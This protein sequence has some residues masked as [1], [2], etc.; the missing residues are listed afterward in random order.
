MNNTERIF[1]H[2]Q[3]SG[4]IADNKKAFKQLTLLW[5]NILSMKPDDALQHI[6]NTITVR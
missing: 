3:W 5:C 2:G 4:A 6:M 1:I